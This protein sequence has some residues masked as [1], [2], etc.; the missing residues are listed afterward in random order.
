MVKFAH[1]TDC[2]LGAWK[3]PELQELSVNAFEYAIDCCIAEKV[4]FVLITGDLFD[5]AMPS[6]EVLKETAMKLKELKEKNI[7]CYVIPG[8]HDF[9]VSGKTFLDVLE[10]AGLFVNIARHKETEDAVELI[11]FEKDNVCMAGIG[12][13]KAGLERNILSKIK[14]VNIKNRNALKIL[15]LHTTL[16]E[17]KPKGMDFI[18]STNA[19]SLP[20][21]FDYYA[22]GHLHQYFNE[23]INNKVLVYP[24]PLFP[25]NFSEFEELKCGSFCI[26]NSNGK[27]KIDKKDVKIKEV[28]NLVISADNKNPEQI[29]QEAIEEINKIDSKI[30]TLRIEGM[31]SRGKTSDIDFNKITETAEKNNN[32]LLKNTSSLRSP[33]FKLE[34]ESKGKDIQEIEKEI[35]GKNEKKPE[36]IEFNDKV[37]S[38]ISVLDIEKQEGETNPTFEKRVID[39]TNKIF[40]M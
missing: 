38:L 18:E 16:S 2:H 20:E 12:G 5:N 40:G 36:F 30:V 3:H 11:F 14:N 29:L 34:I 13:K 9:S 39:E 8:S 10:K 21:G 35:V 28:I 7:D 31:L 1:L 32:L 33:E 25:A 23:T 26:V 17:A 4:K 24:G 6:I 37:E 19:D 22:L 15:A 27:I